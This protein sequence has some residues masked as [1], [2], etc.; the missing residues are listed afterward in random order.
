MK[1][2]LMETKWVNVF[3]ISVEE[4]HDLIC[5]LGSERHDF[6]MN[7]ANCDKSRVGFSLA[8]R[9]VRYNPMIPKTIFAT[10]IPTQGSK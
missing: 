2:M 9:T 5:E 10:H 1:N 7:L 4:F 6:G 3:Y 8:V